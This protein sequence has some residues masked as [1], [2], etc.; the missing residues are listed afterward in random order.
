MWVKEICRDHACH[1][2]EKLL[3]PWLSE[4]N[5]PFGPSNKGEWVA[6]IVLCWIMKDT[7]NSQLGQHLITRQ[8]VSPEMLPETYHFTRLQIAFLK[9]NFRQVDLTSRSGHDDSEDFS[10]SP[11]SSWFRN[12]QQDSKAYLY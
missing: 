5:S 11:V 9:L 3:R 10:V 1:S 7:L 12:A 4:K 8:S 6:F 2:K